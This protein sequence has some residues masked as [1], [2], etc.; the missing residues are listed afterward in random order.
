MKYLI[1]K[2]KNSYINNKKIN[3]NK[4][5]LSVYNNFYM[6]K[7]KFYFYFHYL[8]NLQYLPKLYFLNFFYLLKYKKKK[9]ITLLNSFLSFFFFSG[10]R[11]KSYKILTNSMFKVYYSIFSNSKLLLNYSFF[12]EFLFNLNLN[13]N[14][15]NFIYLLD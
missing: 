7:Q 15:F 3:K 11:I 5:V 10:K 4:V 14:F 9:N 12:K 6:D 8:K 2:K 13:R 1:L